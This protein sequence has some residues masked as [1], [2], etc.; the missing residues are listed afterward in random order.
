MKNNRGFAIST[1]MY[2]ILIL[3]LTIVAIVLSMFNT[4]GNVL[5]KLRSNVQDEI[6]DTIE[7]VNI[8]Y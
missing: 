6:N 8:V 5:S 1:M 2:M 7:S 3:G 4:R